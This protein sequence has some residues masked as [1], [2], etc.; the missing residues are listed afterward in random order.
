MP[1]LALGSTVNAGAGVSVASTGVLAGDVTATR[2]APG[3][4]T[5]GPGDTLFDALTST[6]VGVGAR[7]AREVADAFAD[8]PAR[9]ATT[10]TLDRLRTP[11]PAPGTGRGPAGA[12]TIALGADA[13]PP[14]EIQ[15]LLEVDD[16][17]V[18]QWHFAQQDGA[19]PSQ[20]RG[21]GKQVF[22]IPMVQLPSALPARDE[23]VRAAGIW[24]KALHLIRFDKIAVKAGTT[25][26]Q[27]WEEANRPSILSQIKRSP[28]TTGSANLHP[29]G[30]EWFPNRSRGPFLLLVHGTFSTIGAGFSGLLNETGWFDPLF[31]SY[32]GV[33]AF[34]HPTLSASPDDNALALLKMFPTDAP[35]TL[36]VVCHSRGGLVSRRLLDPKLAAAAGVP[37]PQIRKLLFVG[38]PN[39]GTPL[40]QSAR[41]NALLSVFT[42]ILSFLP[43]VHTAQVLKAVIQAVKQVGTGTLQALPGLLAMDPDN[44]LL[45][46]MD[47]QAAPAGTY[48]VAANFDHSPDAP[49]LN[50]LNRLVDAYF[51]STNDLVVPTDGV[52]MAD[53]YVVVQANRFAA[54]SSVYHTSY[55]THDEIRRQLADWLTSP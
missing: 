42:N 48:A 39:R 6:F 9:I 7:A 20:V 45:R 19:A 13:P 41:W 4:G 28:L 25:L 23:A 17:G 46:A 36:D 3:G 27:N 29:I 38:A 5:R 15:V 53:E 50:A 22:V 21:P 34:D 24:R 16:S 32:Q 37:V 14:D 11:A 2:A 49:V 10:I 52:A 30:P 40:A 18:M 51:A 1:S 44:E 26:I 54:A 33:I 31:D 35:V 55:F 47:H 8:E 43:T 12:P